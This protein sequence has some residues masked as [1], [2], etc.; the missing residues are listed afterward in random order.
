MNE[1]QLNKEVKNSMWVFTVRLRSIRT[2]LLSR[3]C[4]SVRTSVRPFVRLSVCLS[5]ACI[6]TKR[7][8]LAKKVQLWLIGSR[9]RA[10]NL[11]QNRWPWMTL[12][13]VMTECADYRTC[14]FTKVPVEV[15]L[16]DLSYHVVFMFS[17][18]MLCVLVLA[19]YCQK[20]PTDMMLDGNSLFLT[21]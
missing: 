3:F 9:P 7:K 18:G 4:L 12:N 10:F 16:G 15:R 8:H 2:V 1:A 13:G 19:P 21:L 20:C 5:N 14:S 6:V 11:Y 17:C